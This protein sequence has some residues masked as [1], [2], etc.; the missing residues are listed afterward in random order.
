MHFFQFARQ[1]LLFIYMQIRADRN[2]ERQQDGE[3]DFF[4]A[5]QNRHAFHDDIIQLEQIA[6]ADDEDADAQ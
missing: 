4:H 1:T 6:C 3:R 5:F 2:A